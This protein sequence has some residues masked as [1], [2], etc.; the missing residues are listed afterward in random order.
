VS[1]LI[2]SERGQAAREFVVSVGAMV[3]DDDV[4]HQYFFLGRRSAE[5]RVPVIIPQRNVQTT[6]TVARHG[7]ERI[8]LGMTP[9]EAQKLVV[10]E[11]SGTTREVWV[12]AQG[13]VLRVAIPSRG[14]VATRDELPG[15][16]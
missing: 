16:A 9:T 1:A 2:A 5:A 14:I 15:G 11:Q 4:F 12:D 3:L 13:R 6:V 8:E 10:T 7:T